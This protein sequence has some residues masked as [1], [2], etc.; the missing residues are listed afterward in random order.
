MKVDGIG[1]GLEGAVS[2]IEKK[3]AKEGK[4]EKLFEEFVAKV[5]AD[6]KE[7]SLSQKKLIDGDVKNLEELMMKVE[8]ADI[9]L[10]L[11]TEI[12]NKALEAYQEI[13]RMQV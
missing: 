6:L 9:S 12:R 3:D 7:A 4:F 11:I 2:S 1:F 5:N 8:K 10:K 13:M